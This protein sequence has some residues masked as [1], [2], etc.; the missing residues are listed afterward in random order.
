MSVYIEE[1]RQDW[2]QLECIRSR[3]GFAKFVCIH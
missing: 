1:S 2:V 3:S